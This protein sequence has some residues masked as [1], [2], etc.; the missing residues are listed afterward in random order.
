M[1]Q[2]GLTIKT[3]AHPTYNVTGGLVQ[4][5]NLGSGNVTKVIGVYANSFATT[6]AAST[7]TWV[8]GTQPYNSEFASI[9]FELREAGQKA[10]SHSSL[11]YVFSG[12]QSATPL[13]NYNAAF[14]ESFRTSRVCLPLHMG[15]QL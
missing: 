15:R 8:A 13:G 5:G 2:P 1:L 7:L 3:L 6:P 12:R 9:L 4:I 10:V 11:D 14:I